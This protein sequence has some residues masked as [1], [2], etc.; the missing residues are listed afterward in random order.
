M[1][2]EPYRSLITTHPFA[3]PKAG[4]QF[5]DAQIEH[6]LNGTNPLSY[7]RIYRRGV[8]VGYRVVRP[9]YSSDA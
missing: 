6:E 3:K 8:F 2:I 4:D 1:E 9:A 7:M 5:Y